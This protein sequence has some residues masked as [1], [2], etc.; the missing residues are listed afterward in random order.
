MTKPWVRDAQRSG[1][2]IPLSFQVAHSHVSAYHLT[3][4]LF[5][6]IVFLQGLPSGH[7]LYG[8]HVECSL[9]DISQNS[10]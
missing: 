2:I 8:C 10:E 6:H 4:S 3:V 7:P 5:T 1:N 9:T